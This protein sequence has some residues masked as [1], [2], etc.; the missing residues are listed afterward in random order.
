LKKKKKMSF[1]QV[2]S[3]TYNKGKSAE[4]FMEELQDRIR[5][6]SSTKSVPNFLIRYPAGPEIHTSHNSFS[7]LV[8]VAETEQV[9]KTSPGTIAGSQPETN[10]ETED[11]VSSKTHENTQK[12]A[13][14]QVPSPNIVENRQKLCDELYSLCVQAKVRVDTI[15]SRRMVE[16]KILTALQAKLGKF[17]AQLAQEMVQK[18][19]ESVELSYIGSFFYNPE[20]EPETVAQI[21]K[22]QAEMAKG[23]FDLQDTFFHISEELSEKYPHVLPVP[24]SFDLMTALH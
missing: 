7:A 13:L 21:E 8:P 20:P 14:F 1:P 10:T 6:R 15:R 12:T 22:Y 2:K 16:C 24:S 19:K 3:T 4:G 18:E 23:N 9:K 17:Y 11:D 5:T